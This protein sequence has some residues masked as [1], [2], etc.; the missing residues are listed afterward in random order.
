MVNGERFTHPDSRHRVG[1]FVRTFL[2]AAGLQKEAKRIERLILD[3]PHPD[4]L[5][6]QLLGILETL[7]DARA[8]SV[9]KCCS[10]A[11]VAKHVFPLKRKS[12]KFGFNSK[13]GTW[14]CSIEVGKDDEYI[15]VVHNK[16]E[17][18]REFPY[19]FSWA[20]HC[21]IDGKGDLV[22][23]KS[24]LKEIDVSQ[25][26]EDKKEILVTDLTQLFKDA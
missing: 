18:G 16:T 13:P 1:S 17:E 10:Q 14:V 6:D 15:D 4:I 12:V 25:C 2:E 22:S 19:I 7:K 20:C 9:F 21:R 11:I 5:G 3:V 24:Y 23:E 8:V 26:A